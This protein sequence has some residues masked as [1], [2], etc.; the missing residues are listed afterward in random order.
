MVNNTTV[1]SLIFICFRLHYKTT[2]YFTPV[3]CMLPGKINSNYQEYLT[4]NQLSSGQNEPFLSNSI[5]HGQS[6]AQSSVYS[7]ISMEVRIPLEFWKA[8]V[9]NLPVYSRSFHKLEWGRF[10]P[11]SATLY[12]FR[13]YKFGNRYRTYS[14]SKIAVIFI[15]VCLWTL[16]ILDRK[17]LAYSSKASFGY[18]QN[19]S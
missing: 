12:N 2:K 6:S 17:K 14:F 7:L 9:P 18:V 10:E 15:T 3:I 19:I 16:W 11:F 4:C 8:K 1:N 5:W 13:F